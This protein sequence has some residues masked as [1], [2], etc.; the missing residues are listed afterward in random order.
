MGYLN[1]KSNYD[2][3]PTTRVIGFDDCAAEGWQAVCAR[4]RASGA[5]VIT[6]DCY[7]GVYDEELLPALIDGLKPSLVVD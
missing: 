4:L 5:R 2:K 3:Y 6:V 1:R 7:P